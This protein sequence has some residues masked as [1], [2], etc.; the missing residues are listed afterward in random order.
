M[1]STSLDVKG[2]RLMLRVGGRRENLKI[3]VFPSSFTVTY[4][5]Q[6]GGMNPSSWGR[7]PN[8]EGRNR[9]EEVPFW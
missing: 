6:F 9:E 4:I 8:R 2:K 3:G 1:L 5:L 7:S